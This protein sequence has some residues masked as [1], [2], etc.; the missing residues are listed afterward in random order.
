VRRALVVGSGAGGATVARALQGTFDVTILE[1]GPEFRPFRPSLRVP[2]RL[3]RLR[4]LR[5]PRLIGTLFPAMRVRVA[6][7]GMVLVSGRG[8][9]GTTTLATANALR[10]DGALRRLGIDLD[11]EFEELAREVPT[12]AAHRAV[13]SEPSRRMFAA[14]ESLGLEP[15][16]LPKMGHQERCRGC[17]HCVLGCPHGIKWDARAV[18]RD[19]QARGATLR[20]G[21]RVRRIA[22]RD[23]AARGV[24]ATAGARRRFFPAEAVVLAA[25]GLGTPPILRRSGIPSAP[26]LFVDPVLCVA[27]RWPGARQ[28]RELAMPFALATDGALLAPY[29]DRLSYYFD[30]RW[31][32][33][34][35]DIFSIMIKLADESAGDASRHRVRKSLTDADRARL[36]AA[37]DLATEIFARLGVNRR[38]LFLGMLNGGH[39]GG[40]LPL[41]ASE[42]ASLHPPVL[43]GNAW[44]AD[45][46]LFPASPAGPPILTIMAVAKR[47]ARHIA[48][49]LA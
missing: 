2:E 7:G 22:V 36:A 3:K 47:I 31:R 33:P 43:P 25:G 35:S 9:G 38:E 15:R 5:D 30:P 37:V 13:W 32:A 6:R 23:G 41:T 46:T 18:L 8:T 34:A 29:F 11:A 14:C 12:T 24:V 19:A 39:P 40:G 42:A 26:R 20:T 17:G 48:S 49:A 45:A 1:A 10:L 27:A 21:W 28:D 44:V 4:L 16:A